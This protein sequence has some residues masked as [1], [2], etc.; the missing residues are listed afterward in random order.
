[1]VDK[2]SEFEAAIAPIKAHICKTDCQN[3]LNKLIIV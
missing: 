2:S 3:L 1:M